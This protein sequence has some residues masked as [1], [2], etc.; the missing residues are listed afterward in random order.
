MPKNS[1][2]EIERAREFAK[3]PRGQ[4]IFGQALALASEQLKDTEPSNSDDMKF[5]GERLFGIFYA[6]YT[7]EAVA[8]VQ[9]VAKECAEHNAKINA[10]Q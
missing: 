2:K 9:A 3:S 1:Q 10:Q 6:M 7:P 5:L 4:L 8:Q